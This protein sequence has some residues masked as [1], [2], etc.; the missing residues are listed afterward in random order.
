MRLLWLADV[1]RAAGLTVVEE[2]GW[3]TRGSDTY[4][5]VIGVVAHETR[6]S[7]T[8]S[9]TGE[10]DVLINGRV[11]L[12]GPIAQLFLSRRGVWHVVA[13]GTC[14]H[15]KTGWG[16]AFA[17]KGND[18]LLGV[19]A[20]HAESESWADKPVQYDSYV[21]GVAAICEH[22]GWTAAQVVGHKEHQPGDKP[23]PEFS[24]TAFRSAVAARIEGDDMPSTVEIRDQIFGTVIGKGPYNA[25]QTWQETLSATKR[26]E[27]GQAAVLA[28]V[29]ADADTDAILARIDEHA[30]AQREE[31]E[32]IRGQL[33]TDIVA[34]LV[35]AGIDVDVDTV[36]EALRRVLG[37]VD[38]AT[39]A[40]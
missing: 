7:A 22:T 15:V 35:A 17:G 19:E 16:G 39:P 11:G 33:V 23:D 26:L 29:K 12:S 27:L 20:Q 30:A 25:A 21:R 9:V 4:G 31:L 28:A 13:S 10:I 2:P 37:G 38:G 40:V 3:R 1:L 5:P 18:S 32:Q 14:H 24:M 6:G 36:E 8:S 34:G